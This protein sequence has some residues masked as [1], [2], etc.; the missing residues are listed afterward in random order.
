MGFH[1]A[2]VAACL[3]PWLLRLRASLDAQ[4]ERYRQICLPL[5]PATDHNLGYR[6][7]LTAALGRNIALTTV[8][9]TRRFKANAERFA[10][11]LELEGGNARFWADDREQPLGQAAHL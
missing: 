3:N 5:E 10:E 9:V 11:V 2:L 8:L 1:D 7:I 6:D 4:A